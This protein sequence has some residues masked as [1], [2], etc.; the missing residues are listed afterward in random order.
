[1]H[2]DPAVPANPKR[3]VLPQVLRHEEF[4]EGCKATG[5]SHG[6]YQLLFLCCFVS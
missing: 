3:C 5:L 1:A 2:G 6:L 4:E